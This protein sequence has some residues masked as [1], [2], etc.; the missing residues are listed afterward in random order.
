MS[1]IAK[2]NI[3]AILWL[4]HTG[5]EP[6]SIAKELNLTVKQVEQ[7]LEK[8]NSTN[9]NSAVQTSQQPVSMNNKNLMITETLGK[10]IN[11][12]A[13]MTP[14]ASTMSDDLRK[15]TETTNKN[16]NESIFRPKK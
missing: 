6:S 14:Q 8:N 11:S 7:I 13:I 15:K 2:Q 1:K 4:N 9:T 3:Y 5:E 16:T 10:K 12:V